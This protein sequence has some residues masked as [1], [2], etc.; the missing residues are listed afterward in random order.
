VAA[1]MLGPAFARFIF[2][3]DQNVAIP[4]EQVV[5]QVG[6]TIQRYLDGPR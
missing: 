4:D 2:A 6:A 1:Q 3:V 5:T